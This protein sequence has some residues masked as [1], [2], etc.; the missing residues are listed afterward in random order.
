MPN[1]SRI[2]D[3]RDFNKGRSSKFR[4]DSRVRQ[5]TEKGRRTYR[6]KRWGNNNKDEDSSPNI[7]SDKNPLA[8]SQKFRN[9]HLLTLANLASESIGPS[10]RLFSPSGCPVLP[11][12]LFCP[13]VSSVLLWDLPSLVFFRSRGRSRA[14]ALCVGFV[15]KQTKGSSDLHPPLHR[16]KRIPS[17]VSH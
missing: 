5:T 8:S 4:E 2:D 15:R 10:S 17:I 3:P 9:Y 11:T 13:L 1:G 7:L 16:E 6:P 12:D 14:Q